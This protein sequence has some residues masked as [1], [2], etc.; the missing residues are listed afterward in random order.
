MQHAATDTRMARILV[1]EDDSIL[2]MF[3]A[4]GLR[5]VGYHVEAVATAAEAL[6]KIRNNDESFAGAVIDYGLPDRRGDVLA[7]EIRKIDGELPMVI[8]SGYQ[9]EMLRGRFSPDGRTVLLG[10]P[11]DGRQLRKALDKLGVSPTEQ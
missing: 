4:D 10:K 9:E 6:G 2:R 7:A 3:I 1:V 5:E 11:Y 8:A